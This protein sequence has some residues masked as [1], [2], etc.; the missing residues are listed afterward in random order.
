MATIETRQ[1]EAHIAAP[2]SADT[3]LPLPTHDDIRTARLAG[4]QALQ[5]AGVPTLLP[6]EAQGVQVAAGAN[7]DPSQMVSQVSEQRSKLL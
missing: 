2:P 5:A 4:L 7:Q 1:D 3:I 6:H